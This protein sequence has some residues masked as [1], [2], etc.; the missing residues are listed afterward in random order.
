L[1]GVRGIM[2]FGQACEQAKPYYFLREHLPFPLHALSDPGLAAALREAL[3][4][5]D[6][7]GAALNKAWRSSLPSVLSP[8]ARFWVEAEGPFRELVAAL[9]GGDGDL[10]G[11]RERLLGAALAQV[12]AGERDAVREALEGAL[13]GLRGG[14]D[15][16]A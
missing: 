11:W 3:E 10:D 7:I 8:A 2:A 6:A 9:E 16:R 5:A 13:S 12:R 1:D 14:E 4:M 15:A